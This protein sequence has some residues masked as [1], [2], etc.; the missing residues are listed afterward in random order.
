MATAAPKEVPESEGNQGKPKDV[1]SNAAGAKLS[2]ET[3]PALDEKA[4][5]GSEANDMETAPTT[6]LDVRGTA[7]GG[8]SRDRADESATPKLNL[9]D[10]SELSEPPKSGVPEAEESGPR[11]EAKPQ[12]ENT[13]LELPGLKLEGG[14]TAEEAESTRKVEL[15][16]GR[17]LSVKTVGD[18]IREIR[19][20]KNA[21]VWRSED[22]K[23]F[24]REG[25]KPPLQISG[26]F[27]ISESGEYGWRS[28]DSSIVQK[29][30]RLVVSRQVSGQETGEESLQVELLDNKATVIRD[31]ENR[32]IDTETALGEVVTVERDAESGKSTR[33]KIGDITWR[34][35]EGEDA[36]SWTASDGRTYEGEI[37]YDDDGNLVF[38]SKD[39]KSSVVRNLDGSSV[40]KVEGK[41]R[42]VISANGE[43]SSFG[44]DD[45]GAIA[46]VTLGEGTQLVKLPVRS[47]A[48]EGQ[49]GADDFTRWTKPGSTEVV[50]AKVSV[51]DDGT[52]IIEEKGKEAVS[53]RPDGWQTTGD[54]NLR[55]K[56]NSDGSGVT[57][58]ELGLIIESKG[59]DSADAASGDT[60]KFDYDDQGQLAKVKEPDGS[61][62]LR[63]E[64]D[65]NG[66]NWVKEGSEPEESFRGKFVVGENGDVGRDWQVDG[67][68]FRTVYKADGS[69]LEVADGKVREIVNADGR[70]FAFKLSPDNKIVEFADSADSGFKWT[71]SDQTNWTKVN[72]DG[73]PV[74]P[75]ETRQFKIRVDASNASLVRTDIGE[76]ESTRIFRTNGDVLTLDENKRVAE[77]ET[78]SKTIKLLRSESGELEGRVET[79]SEGNSV[80]FDAQD[81]VTA[82]T[83][84]D[85]ARTFKYEGDSTIPVEFTENGTKF[86]LNEELRKESKLLYESE[87]GKAKIPGL[88][89]VGAD[90]TINLRRGDGSDLQIKMDGA[91]TTRFAD[92]SMISEASDGKITETL[93]RNGKRTQYKYDLESDVLGRK[94]QLSEIIMTDGDKVETWRSNNGFDW[95]QRESGSEWKGFVRVD[96]SDGSRIARRS[97]GDAKRYS[98]DGEIKIDN[99][100]STDVR[101]RAR[102]VKETRDYWWDSS[103]VEEVRNQLK[104]LDAEQTYMVQYEYN[105]SNRGQLRQHMDRRL[106]SH[107]WTEVKG[108]L[109]RTGAPGENYAIQLAVDAQEVDR[110]WWNR[111]RSKSEILSSTR[112]ILGSASESER[113][114]I[115]AAHRRMY[116]SGLAD[117]YGEGGA[118]AKIAGWDKYHSELIE[119]AARRGV[120]ARTAD[121][122]SRI[123]QAA[124]QSSDGK[125]LDYF[126]EAASKG[127]AT[128]EGRQ[129]F[130]EDGGAAKI[131]D[132][133]T[134]VTETHEGT[135][136]DVDQDAITEATDYMDRGDLRPITQFRK[137]VGIFSNDAKSMEDALERMKP[138]ERLLYSQGKRIADGGASPST[139]DER[140]ALDY[141]NDWQREFRDAHY[142][143]EER[144]AHRYEDQV[145][146]KGGTDIQK[147]VDTGGNWTNSHQENA[148]I[149]ENMNRKTFDLLTSGMTK[150][151]DG[152]YSSEFLT[153][154]L[155]AQKDNFDSVWSNQYW[156]RA[157]TLLQERVKAAGEL[158]EAIDGGDLDGLRVRVPKLAEIGNEDWQKLK[159][160]HQIESRLKSGELSQEELSSADE[161]ALESYRENPVL[162]AL[163][164]GRELARKIDASPEADRE[165]FLRGL[166][167]EGL[168]TLEQ[169]R[170]LVFE[171]TKAT[172]RRDVSQVAKDSDYTFSTDKN[173]IVDSLVSMKP[174]ER[175]RYRDD[176]EFRE[177]LQTQFRKTL[178]GADSHSWKAAE[179]LLAQ[180][181][182]DKENPVPAAPKLGITEKLYRR[183]G[184]G[185]LSRQEALEMIASELS[186]DK[187]GKLQA[188]LADDPAFREAATAIVGGAE[189]YKQFVEPLIATGRLDTASL[190]LIYQEMSNGERQADMIGEQADASITTQKFHLDEYFKQGVLELSPSGFATLQQN[191]AE[192]DALLEP[193]TA[194]QRELAEKLIEQGEVK[195]EDKIRAFVVDGG[196]GKEE[197]RVLLEKM[198]T[199]ERS[200]VVRDYADKY[201]GQLRHDLLQ[202]VAHGEDALFIRLTRTGEWDAE[203]THLHFN[204]V[205]DSSDSGIGAAL[206]RDTNTMHLQTRSDFEEAKW[207][208]DGNLSAEELKV[209]QEAMQLALEAFR[210]SKES[211]SETVAMGII[212]AGALVAAPFSGGTSLYA[213]IAAGGVVGAGTKYV[214]K[215]N[216]HSGA[217]ELAG[218]FIKFSAL[219]AANI[220]GPEHLVKVARLGTAAAG[221]TT[222]T[223]LGDAAFSGLSQEVKAEVSQGFVKVVQQAITSGHRGVADD[224]IVQMLKG[225]NGL[226]DTTRA[227]MARALSQE[228]KGAL[229][230]TATRAVAETVEQAAAR[231][232]VS[233]LGSNLLNQ[234]RFYGMH[235]LAGSGGAVVGDIGDQWVTTGKID[236]TRLAMTATMGAGFAVPMAGAFR[237]GGYGL[238]RLSGTADDISVPRTADGALDEVPPRRPIGGAER[239]GPVADGSL[240]RVPTERLDF[241]PDDTGLRTGPDAPLW[242]PPR[243]LSADELRV[244]RIADD[245]S[246]FERPLADQAVVDGFAN[247]ML[248]V[249]RNWEDLSP[250][251]SAV[252]ESEAA[253][254]TS[255]ASYNAGIKPLLEGKVPA[256]D[257]YKRDVV[258][259]ALEGQPDDVRAVAMRY[260]DARDVHGAKAREVNRVLYER[261]RQL[262]KAV[263]QFTE[264]NG[265]PSVR[266]RRYGD[267]SES[268]AAYRNGDIKVLTGDLL[269]G[270]SEDFVRKVFHELN[271]A[272]QDQKILSLLADDLKIGAR[273]NQSDVDALAARYEAETGHKVSAGETTR[274][275][276]F[277]SDTLKER[278]GNPLDAAQK[279]RAEELLSGIANIEPVGPLLRET[280]DQYRFIQ[281]RLSE[282]VSDSPE[283]RSAAADLIDSLNKSGPETE[284]LLER[285]FGDKAAP[286]E[287]LRV[288]MKR[289]DPE[290]GFSAEEARQVLMEALGNR[291][292]GLNRVRQQAYGRYAGT[293]HEQEAAIADRLVGRAARQRGAL[294]IETPD[295]V[296]PRDIAGRTGLRSG[297]L[298]QSAMAKRRSLF[299]KKPLTNDVLDDLS[300]IDTPKEFFVAL[301]EY[302]IGGS[303]TAHQVEQLVTIAS[304]H[305]KASKPDVAEAILHLSARRLGDLN[306]S[307]QI[308][309]AE[310]TTQISQIW[311]AA[312]PMS[313]GRKPELIA[314]LAGAAPRETLEMLQREGVSSERIFESLYSGTEKRFQGRDTHAKANVLAAMLEVSGS[315][316]IRDKYEKLMSRMSDDVLVHMRRVGDA[317][318]QLKEARETFSR[319]LNDFVDV[320]TRRTSVDDSVKIQQI[321]ALPEVIRNLT[322]QLNASDAVSF[323]RAFFEITGVSPADE[324]FAS[325]LTHKLVNASASDRTNMVAAIRRSANE[326]S[327]NMNEVDRLKS[328]L[329]TLAS[330]Q[331]FLGHF[332]PEFFSELT[333]DNLSIVNE[334]FRRAAYATEVDGLPTTYDSVQRMIRKVAGTSDSE[335]SETV[336]ALES[337]YKSVPAEDLPYL[338][339]LM[340]Q[341]APYLS[342]R[343]LRSEFE[344]LA[345]DME[346][347]FYSQ[348]D[349]LTAFR[350]G[351]RVGVFV[352][353]DGSI[354]QGLAYIFRKQTGVEL[355]VHVTH[356]P[357]GSIIDPRNPG[358]YF[359]N[360]E[361]TADESLMQ[362]WSDYVDQG[363]Y[364]ESPRAEDLMRFDS[365]LNLLDLAV[366]RANGGKVTP[367]IQAKINSGINALKAADIENLSPVASVDE[368][369]SSSA[370]EL[371]SMSPSELRVIRGAFPEE[372]MT[373]EGLKAFSR[374]IDAAAKLGDEVSPEELELIAKTNSGTKFLESFT[375]DNVTVDDMLNARNRI[376][377]SDLTDPEKE[378][379]LT[380]LLKNEMAG[381]SENK[382]RILKARVD[383]A[384]QS[385]TSLANLSKEIEDARVVDARAFAYL[386]R[387]QTIGSGFGDSVNMTAQEAALIADSATEKIS[388]A[389]IAN[390]ARTLKTKLEERLGGDLDDVVF[391]TKTSDGGSNMLVTS[392]FKAANG[393][394]AQD[395]RFIPMEHAIQ[396]AREG[397]LNGKKIVYLDDGVY[398][399]GQTAD[400]LS[401]LI[402]YAGVNK[403]DVFAATLVS[404]PKG[405]KVL[406]DSGLEDNI[407]FAKEYSEAMDHV[408]YDIADRDIPDHLK[409]DILDIAVTML[410]KNEGG[411]MVDETTV[412]GLIWPYMVPNNNAVELNDFVARYL[413]LARAKV[414]R[415]EVARAN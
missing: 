38:S 202:K 222:T 106:D 322:K 6:I 143:G 112:H 24:T 370:T 214:L 56:V 45:K 121:D 188:E 157:Q 240:E 350:A 135:Y 141:Y 58:N 231:G 213:I 53:R 26:E 235:G 59:A 345:G 116:D 154:M 403:D 198:S 34:R 136:V 330:A 148:T 317:Q 215:G 200:R 74:E 28:E 334:A 160:G 249:T 382:I 60:W 100:L 272:E 155:E 70:S 281:N 55:T 316:R 216:D 79:D 410:Q 131:K 288:M 285:M 159:Q 227:A 140:K 164:D 19:D 52:I 93:D 314:S 63:S 184:E 300:R 236:T 318:P 183:S 262:Q 394:D 196:V 72:A 397:K 144:K 71:T 80:T 333:P 97:T 387:K 168:T 217:R 8:E 94:G 224:A 166:G 69:K 156:R 201:Q 76:V 185:D 11:L 162:K 342:V 286:E 331:T 133:F 73:S 400:V 15:E 367:E 142:F 118:G 86:V 401:D 336:E 384:G 44:Y 189:V 226:D 287:V 375:R 68:D 325:K 356:G 393:M 151:A 364:L 87:D 253:L 408:F 266:I 378:L 291:L 165:E 208:A 399:G 205:I 242:Q 64:V 182:G 329:E 341:R 117:F 192:R 343:S 362:S 134:T 308:S 13:N 326:L 351:Q 171:S 293:L 195:P 194:G 354:G 102:V 204:R 275:H 372:E 324:Q 92:G 9:L 176:A 57:K 263:D 371:I 297:D 361:N 376:I 415:E 225:V 251:V 374:R 355:D 248:S 246:P 5:S 167:R 306:L 290:A 412:S 113:Q 413:G 254:D 32:I 81:R 125:R 20:S 409:N 323:R 211:T 337:L 357:D 309:K 339:E 319:Y 123:M 18:Q 252:K 386:L 218:D 88:M 4:G 61:T 31:Q 260:F 219:T 187:D 30:D 173:A 146:V 247:D 347:S 392:V 14:E 276:K 115:D 177:Q 152:E 271:H 232:R 353:G 256:N 389:D 101:A 313:P 41:V 344:G 138:E 405:L 328:S 359:D 43:R 265:L 277:I 327:V 245:I 46:S 346:D 120:D 29:S 368:A 391:V 191:K 17:T 234:G 65:G 332:K 315:I 380:R 295:E 407:I 283:A 237:L 348:A 36:S 175:V 51:Q 310:L 62:W 239:V 206:T 129:R 99:A 304:R 255:L 147:I 298:E 126:R 360:F 321:N 228:F 67:R 250:M 161:S 307:S 119:I 145:L 311:K 261:T 267:L 90:G 12:A 377:K 174:E 47:G 42:E 37:D 388:F 16:G 78:D 278:N 139:N 199:E 104:D 390:H 340:R 207:K 379:L 111:D 220:L 209:H 352:Q 264:A 128:D 210:E 369:V 33:V 27:F 279:V 320:S 49:E 292:G 96:P 381:M 212:T 107:R 66:D 105:P 23:T 274:W 84:G 282:I 193:M 280:A 169:Y 363:M 91:R 305:I 137:A 153:R 269:R 238:R 124:L 358:V 103:V 98:L 258:L 3:Q 406:R 241:S 85:R 385:E 365:G 296:L 203:Q 75:A 284:R 108:Y 270:N 89:T 158:N 273:F 312:E 396:L 179:R 373:A 2:A 109:D 294:D 190:K 10:V 122:Q 414:F 366:I 289:L 186:G 181:E 259:K 335:I 50:E 150:G 39:G 301:K 7:D 180:I 221:R 40:V 349:R 257:I 130:R 127:F 299:G 132:A 268:G 21:A 338:R 229:Q 404:H 114:N 383:S 170:E 25:T 230:S 411:K 402:D 110:W 178:G 244:Q 233:T 95:R 77:I 35:G 163:F 223:V 83:Q 149:I 303:L 197:V 22:G 48:A 54:S 395:P 172:A 243:D 398:S 1:E 302:D 82:S